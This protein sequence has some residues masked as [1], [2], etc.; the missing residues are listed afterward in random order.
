LFIFKLF[1]YAC[2][3]A[4]SYPSQA[5]RCHPGVAHTLT[6]TMP[7]SEAVLQ[8]ASNWPSENH[9]KMVFLTSAKQ[10]HK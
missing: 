1:A 2:P 3:A 4:S 10:K 9:N 8:S 6:N 5:Q 7:A